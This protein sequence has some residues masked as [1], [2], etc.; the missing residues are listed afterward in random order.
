M[1]VAKKLEPKARAGRIAQ[2]PPAVQ[3]DMVPSFSYLFSIP[4][5]CPHC[6]TT[7]I[8][9]VP[10]RG[11]FEVLMLP[12][13][14]LHVFSCHDCLWRFYSWRHERSRRGREQPQSIEQIIWLWPVQMSKN[15]PLC[16]D[17][18]TRRS[19]RNN[20]SERILSWALRIWPFRCMACH[21]RF[22][23]FSFGTPRSGSRGRKRV[24]QEAD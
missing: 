10:R 18:D 7:R 12:L 6:G 11:S 22:F 19:H 20:G 13:L 14:R 1:L 3:L 15:C 2:P 23:A 5:Q 9:C 8:D 4:R 21:Y 16:G 24:H 17:A